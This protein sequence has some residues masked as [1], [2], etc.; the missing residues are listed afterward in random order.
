MAKTVSPIFKFQGTIEDLTFV[1]SKR[2]KPHVRARKNSKT[3]FVMT[4]AL[5]E[6]KARLQQCNQYAKPVFQALKAELPDGGLWSRLVSKLF[7]E[8]KAGRPLGLECLK[9][10]ECNLQHP[11]SEV[12]PKGYDLSATRS[13]NQLGVYVQLHGHPAADDKMPRTGYQLRFVVITPD[14]ENGTVTKMEGLGPLTK[15]TDELTAH[16]IPIGL[17][18][19][20]PY[21]LLMGIVPHLRNEGPVKIM[22]D[23]GMKVVWVG[24]QAASYELRAASGIQEGKQASSDELRAT[25]EIQEGME[26]QAAD[27]REASGEGLVASGLEEMAGEVVE[28]EVSSE[29]GVASKGQP[30]MMREEISANEVAEVVAFGPEA[31]EKG[32]AGAGAR[33]RRKSKRA[34]EKTSGNRTTE[35]MERQAGSYELPATS[36]RAPEMIR[37][38]TSANGAV[39]I[40]GSA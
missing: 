7:A 21:L 4:A 38:E 35:V 17:P 37:E 9:D 1:N 32:T 6:S 10:L 34:S 2:Y 28:G 15:Y 23:S 18:G 24:S 40:S 36:G 31:A 8:L 25:S 27:E 30:E 19:T 11:L 20:G 22:S 26:R 12:L 16:D 33:S 29:W 5:A 3:P 13:Q 39:E 14:A